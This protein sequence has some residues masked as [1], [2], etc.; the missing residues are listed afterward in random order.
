[1]IQD[2]PSVIAMAKRKNR[3]RVTFWNICAF[4]ASGGSI[5]VNHKQVRTPGGFGGARV[6]V[7]PARI[8]DRMAEPAG[9][10]AGCTGSYRTRR[11]DAGG[12]TAETYRREW[13]F[14]SGHDETEPVVG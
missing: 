13:L 10:P 2:T 1:M 11:R 3:K 5:G 9:F 6:R 7:R 14:N 12:D 4:E 8:G